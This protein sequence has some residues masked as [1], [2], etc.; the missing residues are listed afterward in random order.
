MTKTPSIAELDAA[1]EAVLSKRVFDAL[2]DSHV[3]RTLMHDMACLRA[4]AADRRDSHAHVLR[5]MWNELARTGFY[6]EDSFK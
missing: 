6:P 3:G 5:V 4:F 1:I 2:Q